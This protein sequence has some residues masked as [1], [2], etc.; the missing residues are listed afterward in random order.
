[1][2]EVVKVRAKKADIHFSNL[3][4][5]KG[6]ACVAEL[7]IRMTDAI[8]ATADHVKW[9]VALSQTFTNPRLHKGTLWVW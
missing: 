1:M 7:A 2:T 9:R 6:A 3:G 8:E 4:A 5:Y